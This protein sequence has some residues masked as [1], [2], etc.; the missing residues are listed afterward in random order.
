[1]HHYKST[2]YAYQPLDT[3][4]DRDEAKKR[5]AAEKGIKLIV[6]PYW[7][8]GSQERYVDPFSLWAH[9]TLSFTPPSL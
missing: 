3:F 4:Q 7:W 9:L 5:L 8:D 2:R 6:V 1:M